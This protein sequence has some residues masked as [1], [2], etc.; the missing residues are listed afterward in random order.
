MGCWGGPLYR[1]D[2]GCDLHPTGGDLPVRP[3][4]L[5]VPQRGHRVE[6]QWQHLRRV[7]H[8]RLIR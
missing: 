1:A 5:E 4:Q 2:K 8:I 6:G 3:Q 7:R